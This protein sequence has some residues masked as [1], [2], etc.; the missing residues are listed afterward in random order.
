MGSLFIPVR[1][2]FQGHDNSTRYF[3]GVLN[4]ILIILSPFAL[5]NKSF[6][7]D[8]LLFINFTIFFILMVFF[9]EQ[10]AFSMEQIVRYTL[11]VIPVLSI[12]T[13]MGLINI[14]NWTMS[15][16]IRSR[17]VFNGFSSFFF[18]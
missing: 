11:S 4:P 16:S 18:Y 9:L 13:V 1:I 10:K 17:K 14:W 3:D 12:L 8:K 2:F 5:M 7:R 15:H 6:Y